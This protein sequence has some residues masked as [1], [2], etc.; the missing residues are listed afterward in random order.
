MRIPLFFAVAAFSLGAVITLSAQAPVGPVVPKVQTIG[1]YEQALKRLIEDDATD[2]LWQ[3]SDAKAL[4]Q[5]M[6]D[7]RKTQTDIE[8]LRIGPVTP[9]PVVKPKPAPGTPKPRKVEVQEAFDGLQQTLRQASEAS[10]QLVLPAQQKTE[11]QRLLDT[12]TRAA[13]Q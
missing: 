12:L 2:K 1:T 8:G 3:R 6:Q 5:V 13:Q 10:P 4:N 9:K 7:V 11:L